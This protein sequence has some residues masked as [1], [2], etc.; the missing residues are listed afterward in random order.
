MVFTEPP[1]VDPELRAAEF[2]LGRGHD[3][4]IA[5]PSG[6]AR[7]ALVEPPLSL[8]CCFQASG[9][10]SVWF[11]LQCLR[12]LTIASSRRPCCVR[13]IAKLWREIPHLRA[14]CSVAST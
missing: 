13:T 12:W 3:G 4:L 1:P 8:K 7:I 9:P 14:D 10:R 2:V 5:A 11:D 6:T